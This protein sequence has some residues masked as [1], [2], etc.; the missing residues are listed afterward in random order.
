VRHPEHP[1]LPHADDDESRSVFQ[2]EAA[3]SSATIAA[4]DPTEVAE[5]IDDG[6]YEPEAAAESAAAPGR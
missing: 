6:V 2:S 4:T 5:P 1:P 3:A